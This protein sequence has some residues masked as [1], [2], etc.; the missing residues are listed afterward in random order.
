[1]KGIMDDSHRLNGDSNVGSGRP[2][3]NTHVHLP[4]N[5]SAFD[6]AEDA[7][8]LAAAEGV[9]A[10]GTANSIIIALQPDMSTP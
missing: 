6:T 3:V 9:A 7:V 10:L 8:R 4:P 2:I 5:F 1:M